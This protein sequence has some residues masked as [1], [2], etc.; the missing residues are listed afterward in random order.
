MLWILVCHLS[1]VALTRIHMFRL[2]R[3]LFGL[4]PQNSIRLCHPSPTSVFLKPRSIFHISCRLSSRG[5]LHTSPRPDLI[6]PSS[7]RSVSIGD[8]MNPRS[9]TAMKPYR[10]FS[11]VD[12]SYWNDFPLELR[13]IQRD[14]SGFLYVL[15][16]TF[17][18]PG[19]GLRAD[20][21]FLVYHPGLT[22]QTQNLNFQ[23]FLPSL[24]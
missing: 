11:R 14:L 2:M 1:I 8:Y 24:I 22:T 13:S 20:L 18:F 10:A 6:M 21:P 15:L 16:K 7:L 17:L 19:P 3:C 5:I 12:P 23:S 4:C 9:R